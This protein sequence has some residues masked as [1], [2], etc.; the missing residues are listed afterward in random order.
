MG[1]ARDGERGDGGTP[2][3]QPEADHVRYEFLLSV[4]LSGAARAAFPELDAGPGP[5]GGTAM[6]GAVH[7]DTHLAELLS[8]FA[9]LGLTVVEM[10]QLPD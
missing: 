6:W 9:A 5:T 1:E 8:R 2:P 7:D 4:K 10:R 3:H